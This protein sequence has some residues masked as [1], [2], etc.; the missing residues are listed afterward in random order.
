MGLAA[1]GLAACASA[2]SEKTAATPG[3]DTADFK[4]VARAECRS[5]DWFE[6]GERDGL[7]G[8]GAGKLKER[9]ARCAEFGVAVNDAD[10]ADGRA[11][12]LRTYCKPDRGFDAG[13][14]GRAYHGVC[15]LEVEPAFLAEYGIGRRLFDLTSALA[16]AEQDLAN[17]IAK[18]G[19]D[20]FELARALDIVGDGAHDVAERNAASA[21]VARL[22]QEIAD[23]ETDMGRLESTIAAAQQA[24]DAHRAMLD[25]RTQIRPAQKIK[26]D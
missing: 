5:A 12:G 17:A 1:L 23:L 25:R 22:R 10:Y 15:P 26:K 4:S 14:N 9:T 16:T 2:G 8:E 19:S 20:R 3:D 6:V 24:L 13:R 18:I 11:R 21:D 7:Y